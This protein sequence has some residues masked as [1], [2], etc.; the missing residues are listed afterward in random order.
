MFREEIG[1]YMN[2]ETYRQVWMKLSEEEKAEAIKGFT[3][4][5]YGGERDNV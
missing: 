4:E 1:V 5:F 3:D 2:R